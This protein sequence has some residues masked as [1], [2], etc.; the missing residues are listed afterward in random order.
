MIIAVHGHHLAMPDRALMHE[1]ALLQ[2]SVGG[3]VTHI[4]RGVEAVKLGVGEDELHRRAQ[5]FGDIAVSPKVGVEA[6][7]YAAHTGILNIEDGDVVDIGHQDREYYLFV[8]HRKENTLGRHEGKCF[9]SKK[10][11]R[12]LRIYSRRICDAIFAE[13]HAQ[14]KVQLAIGEPVEIAHIGIVV[15]LITRHNLYEAGN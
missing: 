13:C 6:V 11:G 3:G 4:R 5:G 9:A 1:A 14:Q 8:R 15:P 2:H 7:A 10:G 12:N